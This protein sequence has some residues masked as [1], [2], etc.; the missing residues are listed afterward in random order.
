VEWTSSKHILTGPESTNRL[1]FWADGEKLSVYVNGVLLE[2]VRDDTY[3]QGAFGAFIA[4]A[5]TEG[6]T[7][8]I[9]EAAYWELP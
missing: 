1:G 4:A 7:V 2:E 9:S 5:E 8:E 6:F 3:D